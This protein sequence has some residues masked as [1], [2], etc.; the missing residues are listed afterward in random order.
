MTITLT[1]E[2]EALINQ[3][4]TDGDFDTPQEV[5]MAA[6]HFIGNRHYPA[7]P[8]PLEEMRREIMVG[9]NQSDRGE[10]GPLDAEEIKAA[11]CRLLA[12]R[13]GNF[14]V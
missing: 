12:E 10:H 13:Q 4:V 8:L 5:I 1:P 14:S 2:Q 6:L 3:K 9:V 7:D 11:G